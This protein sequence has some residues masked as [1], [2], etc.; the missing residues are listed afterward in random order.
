M[1]ALSGMV[2]EAVAAIRAAEAASEEAQ[3]QVEAAERQLKQAKEDLVQ[4][5]AKVQGLRQHAW[6]LADDFDVDEAGTRL[7]CLLFDCGKLRI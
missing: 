4:S 3:A 5:F 7:P 1:M 2:E 6:R